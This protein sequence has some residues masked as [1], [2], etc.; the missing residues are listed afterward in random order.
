ML[1]EET[2]AEFE[3]LDILSQLKVAVYVD[4]GI[5]L[6]DEQAYQLLNLYLVK[7]SFSFFKKILLGKDDE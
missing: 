2:N 1:L 3:S 5:L 4:S 6:S 7:C